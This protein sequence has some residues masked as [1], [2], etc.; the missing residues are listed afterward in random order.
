MDNYS[1]DAKRYINSCETLAFSYGHS[2][3]TSEHLLLALLRNKELLL[4]TELAKKKITFDLIAKKLKSKYANSE[5]D[6]LY[7][8][9]SEELKLLF[10][11]V[12]IYSHSIREEI[13]SVNSL[14]YTILTDRNC[15]A[16]QLL[17]EL[18]VDITE[19]KQL[20]SS[21]YAKIAELE[22]IQDLHYMS[23]ENK[24][25]LIGRE[26]ELKQLINALSR[27]N[28]PNA[29][30]VGLPGVGKT[31]IV[32]EL[33]YLLEKDLVPSL[34]GKRI[35]E[36]D[37]AS[38]VGGTKYRGEFEDK[39]KK[40]IKKV[41]EVGNVILFVD[42]IHTIIHAGGAEGAIDASNILKPYLS[43]GDIQMIGATTDE[44]FTSF[45]QDKPLKRRFQIIKVDPST[46]E[47][48]FQIL[49]KIKPLY[50]DFY[51]TTI[52]DEMLSYII[53][54]SDVYIK[55]QFFPDKAID[56]L[57]NTL[58]AIDHPMTK[59]DINSTLSLYYNIE[60]FTQ[61]KLNILF[62]SLDEEIYGQK[63]AIFRIKKAMNFMAFKREDYDNPLL[64]MLLVGPSGVG[65]SKTAFLIGEKLFGK[66]NICY[67]NMSQYQDIYSLSKLTS[68]QDN[69]FIKKIKSNPRILLIIDELEKASLE[70]LDFFMQILDKGGFYDVSGKYV[71]M[72]DVMIIMLS[73]YG[74][75]QENIF[76]NNIELS[77]IDSIKKKLLTRFRKEFISRID[78]IIIY[79][80][81]NKKAGEKIASKYLSNYSQEYAKISLDFQDKDYLKFGARYIKN[82]VKK[83]L[84]DEILISKAK[85]N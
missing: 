21:Q 7:M 50:E 23:H 3:I 55:E 85:I 53:D 31:A 2:S 84:S 67:L 77:S 41:K 4:T 75:D 11:H 20:L 24:D 43:R 18:K 28:K 42:E 32:E 34:K 81:L 12:N 36:F 51:K 48:T 61:D 54:M 22:N 44:E 78:D 65:K 35:Y 82:K 5:N 49:Q 66:D 64:S 52:D 59:E 57:D 19:L 29:I 74:F 17:V 37:I 27:R 39:V 62:K 38:T 70:V 72:H 13:V 46:K 71:S 10:S 26:K 80:Y 63:E 68:A 16:Y 14:I 1:K 45:D 83:Q 30:L 58:V 56:M 25:P 9:Y 69:G 6:P 15:Y 8:T 60:D 40:V 79:N 76:K 47:E 73:N 33:A